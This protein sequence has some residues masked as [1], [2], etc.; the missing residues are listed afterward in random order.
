MGGRLKYGPRYRYTHMTKEESELWEKFMIMFPDRY[1]T[2]DYDFRVGQGTKLP[3]GS[4]DNWLRMAKMLSQ[5]RIDVIGWVGDSPVIIEVKKRVGLGT[6]GQ[7][8]GYKILFEEN[9][10][11]IIDPE[12]L[13]ICEMLSAD[14]R[15]VLEKNNVPVVVV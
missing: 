12:V 2:V 3:E 1:E 5:K 8:L 4:G 15:Y 9:F 11:N 14:D 10:K 13:V 6:L 7:V